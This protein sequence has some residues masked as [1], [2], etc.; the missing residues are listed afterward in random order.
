MT[1][2][3][4][5]TSNTMTLTNAGL[6]AQASASAADYAKSAD[7]KNA[8][9]FYIEFTWNNA[10]GNASSAIG[11]ADAAR[12]FS[13]ASPQLHGLVI[14]GNGVIYGNSNSLTSVTGPVTNS[15]TCFAVDFD[16]KTFWIRSTATGNWNGS[17]TANPAASTG[18]LSFNGID[19]LA[20]FVQF[21]NTAD[22]VTLNAGDTAFAGTVPSGFT[23]GWPT[24][25]TSAVV[26]SQEG[27]EVWAD[28]ASALNVSLLGIETWAAGTA[29]LFASQLGV[30]IWA[31]S[32][33]APVAAA[34]G[35]VILCGL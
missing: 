15:V 6:T 26:A 11:V 30:E 34:S 33:A 35:V 32:L 2:T 16:N 1:N 18:G 3:V 28:G 17:A 23:A 29:S 10:T 25:T 5:S 7:F 31:S 14:G 24:G 13:N 20:P 4:F 22:Q 8:G 19:F 12:V 27:V 9:K 21:G